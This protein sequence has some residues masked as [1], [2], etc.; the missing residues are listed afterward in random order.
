MNDLE[1]YRNLSRILLKIMSWT[2]WRDEDMALISRLNH[3]V[4]RKIKEEVL[5]TPPHGCLRLQKDVVVGK[6]K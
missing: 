4:C 2:D 3:E 6:D 5:S 1:L